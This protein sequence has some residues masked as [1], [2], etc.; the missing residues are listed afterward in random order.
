LR[1]P[2]GILAAVEV[3][4][5]RRFEGWRDFADAFPDANSAR[6]DVGD[7]REECGGKKFVYRMPHFREE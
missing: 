5:A 2:L 7:F 3:D 4:T 1:D 6:N